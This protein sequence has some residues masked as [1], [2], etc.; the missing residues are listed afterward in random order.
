MANDTKFKL[1][2]YTFSPVLK[3]K[4]IFIL[5]KLLSKNNQKI[6]LKTGEIVDD[7]A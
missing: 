4:T 3:T 7:L 6:D 1:T 5:K 2:P